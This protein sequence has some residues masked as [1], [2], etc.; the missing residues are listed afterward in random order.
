MGMKFV[1]SIDI[2]QNGTS[3]VIG[4]VQ[5]LVHSEKAI[6]EGD[7]DLEAT[8]SVGISGLNTYYALRKIEK[9][10]YVRLNEVPKF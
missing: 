8:D 9:H 6:Q 3:L 1:E 4:E 10:P 7:I 2:K 5:L